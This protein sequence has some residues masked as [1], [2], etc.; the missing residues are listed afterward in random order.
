M[1]AKSSP[2]TRAAAKQLA[3]TEQRD[4]R[5]KQLLRTIF[6][7]LK[8]SGGSK[9][10]LGKQAVVEIECRLDG[11]DMDAFRNQIKLITATLQRFA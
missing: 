2:A 1:A 3:L 7:E 4:I 10:S 5:I 6:N 11:G 9:L 8:Q